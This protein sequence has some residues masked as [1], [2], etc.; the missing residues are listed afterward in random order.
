MGEIFLSGLVMGLGRA[1]SLF[2]RSVGE[3]RSQLVDSP[4]LVGQTDIA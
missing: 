1:G 3:V 2:S 4:G